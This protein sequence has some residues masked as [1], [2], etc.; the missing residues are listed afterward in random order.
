VKIAVLGSTIPLLRNS[1]L[2]LM[3]I[4]GHPASIKVSL[5]VAYKYS[6]KPAQRIELAHIGH[7]SA[8]V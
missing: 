6:L 5:L 2:L 3:L 7:A 4:C 1:S 8:V